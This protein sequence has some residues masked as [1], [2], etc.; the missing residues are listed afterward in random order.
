VPQIEV[1]FD[2]D[3]NGILNVSAK[4]T[5]TGKSQAITITASSGLGKA[6]V[7]K[8][9]KEAEAHAEE[10]KKRREVVDLRNQID[11]A[12]YQA[13]KVAND[14]REKLGD[15][16]AKSLEEA[17]AE[18]RKVAEGD[19]A[20]ALKDTLARLQQKSQQAAESLYKQTAAE[21][22]ASSPGA[23]APK[24]DD[25]VDAEYTVKQ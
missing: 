12:A 15:A 23:A 24:Q 13:E 6:E 4:D 14:N 1:T 20:Q 5:A 9:V 16:E 25:V 3:A 22:K 19:D 8:M 2:I 17:A 11:T 7:E 21:T 10:D 18:A